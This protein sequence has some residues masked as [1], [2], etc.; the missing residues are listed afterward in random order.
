MH[1][2][3]D[4][5]MS[6]LPIAFPMPFRVLPAA[7]LMRAARISVSTPSLLWS[8][9][10]QVL[11]PGTDSQ[12]EIEFHF[13]RR[14]AGSW[15]I[16]PDVK[17]CRRLISH[18]GGDDRHCSTIEFKRRSLRNRTSAYRVIAA[19]ITP[20][21]IF[22]VACG[23]F[24]SRVFGIGRRSDILSLLATGVRGLRRNTR[25]VTSCVARSVDRRRR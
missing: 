23:G 7:S 5:R 25:P 13:R 16:T 14:P 17:L 15:R 19:V 4:E 3:G 10:K 6:S 11:P 22:G 9:C 12:P 18:S 1:G 20:S 21:R 2:R 8:P 24:Q